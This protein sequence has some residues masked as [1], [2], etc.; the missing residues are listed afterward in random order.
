LEII[1]IRKNLRGLSAEEIKRLGNKSGGRFFRR[2]D[3]DNV[4]LQRVGVKK[5]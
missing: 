2:F 1:G 5:H 3:L 4:V